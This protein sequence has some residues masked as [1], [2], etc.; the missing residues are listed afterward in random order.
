MLAVEVGPGPGCPASRGTEL[1]GGSAEA[2]LGE[3]G[4]GDGPE[5]DE[6]GGG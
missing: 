6:G 4:S 3:P 2:L 1:P 5:D